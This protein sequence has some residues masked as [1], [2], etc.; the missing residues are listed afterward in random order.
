MLLIVGFFV[1]EGRG[2]VM[3][4]C[5]LTLASLAGLE[6]AV[7]EHL[8]GFRSHS[9]VLAGAVTL[10]ALAAG[11][12]LL[13]S[14]P[15]RP[16]PPD[17]SGGVRDLLLRLPRAVQAQVR[18][19]RVPLMERARRLLPAFESA[20][21]L[22]AIMFMGSLVLWVGVPV[23]WLWVGSQV[24]GS[25][26]MAAAVGAMMIG[27][28]VTIAVLVTFLGWLNRK[29]VELQEARGRTCPRTRRRRSNT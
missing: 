17:R 24:Q 19:P 20:V 8:A 2:A 6:L 1:G 28:L 26:S 5:G 13:P 10:V 15:A 9:T 18:G 29:H 25:S 11:Y 21:L 27:M 4:A 3:I 7:R 16:Q 23:A 14:E 22:V 12:F